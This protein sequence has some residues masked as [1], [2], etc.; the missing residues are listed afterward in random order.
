MLS[1]SAHSKLRNTTA[2][3]RQTVLE[4]VRHAPATDSYIIASS[5]GEQSDWLRNLAKNPQVTIQV[6]RRRIA[7][8]AKRLAPSVVEEELRAYARR[9][10]TA[11]R[12][13]AGMMTGQPWR[14]EP[15]YLR[16]LAQVLPMLALTPTAHPIGAADQ[17][18]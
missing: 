17:P 11:F 5:W 15:A 2:V 10:P 3:P 1:G 18:K 8:T 6:G 16:E 7:V 14:D 4:V 13:L 12:K 9:H